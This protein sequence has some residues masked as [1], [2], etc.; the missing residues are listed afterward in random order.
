MALQPFPLPT[1][2]LRFLIVELF[3]GDNNLTGY[4]DTD[5]NEMLEGL[6]TDAA[7]LALTDHF[8]SSAKAVRLFRGR[9]DI[10]EEWGEIDTGDPATLV[11]FLSR[12]LASVPASVPVALGFWDHGSGVFDEDDPQRGAMTR[13]RAFTPRSRSLRQRP[14]RRLFWGTRPTDPRLRAMLHDDTNGG[15]LTT[16]EAGHVI[17]D[18]LAAS[19]RANLSAIF[20]DTC[21]NGMVEVL[22]EFDA[23]TDVVVGSEDLEP[24]DGWDYY[25]WLGSLASGVV[26]GQRLGR[27]AVEAYQQAYAPRVDLFPCTL[28]AFTQAY[29]IIA[30]FRQLIDAATPLG[31]PGFAI[32]DAAR[33]RCQSFDRRDSY[34]I[35]DF[36]VRL[37]TIASDAAL[38]CAAQALLDAVESAHVAHCALGDEVAQSNGLAFWFPSSRGEWLK[39]SATY[40]ELRFD[41]ETGWA[42][43]IGRFF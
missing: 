19:G 39:T 30:A 38:Q 33:R 6:P 7:V 29:A 35:A 5:L 15:L 14:R 9:I 18:S 8:G 42:R 17:R 31:D 24:G 40:S 23:M 12:A 26:D 32:L 28:G 22:A 25:R 34:D 13:G 21:L 2:D 37:K 43:Y 36:A 1:T 16:L 11:A 27:T 20:S 41:R 4:V 10:L 3:G